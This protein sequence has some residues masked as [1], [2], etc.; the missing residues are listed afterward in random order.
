[1]GRRRREV[2]EQNAIGDAQSH[3]KHLR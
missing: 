2:K 1:M 3:I